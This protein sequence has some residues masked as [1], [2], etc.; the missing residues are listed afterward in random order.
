MVGRV[1]FVAA[2]GYFSMDSPLGHAL[3]IKAV[4]FEVNVEVPGGVKTFVVGGV[5][6]EEWG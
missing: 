5:R 6:Y 3:M 1:E 4:Y 2:T